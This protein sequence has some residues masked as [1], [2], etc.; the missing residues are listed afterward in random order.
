MYQPKFVTAFGQNKFHRS[1][2]LDNDFYIFDTKERL[3]IS[4]YRVGDVKIKPPQLWNFKSVENR[5]E[6]FD[7]HDLKCYR[8]DDT[9]DSYKMSYLMVKTVYKYTVFSVL[10]II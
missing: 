9:T 5:D 6:Y 3:Y 1:F 4:K 10:E 8:F 2:K 7:V